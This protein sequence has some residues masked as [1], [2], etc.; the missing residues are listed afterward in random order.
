M[1]PDGPTANWRDKR[2][3]FVAIFVAIF[4]LSVWFFGWIVP[5]G[6]VQPSGGQ[7]VVEPNTTQAIDR[8]NRLSTQNACVNFDLLSARLNSGFELVRSAGGEPE[9]ELV[10]IDELAKKYLNEHCGRR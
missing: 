9:T 6:I 2:A 8:L 10:A 3:P 1:S 5:R 4:A 7:E